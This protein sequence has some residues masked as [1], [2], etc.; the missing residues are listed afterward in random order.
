MGITIATHNGSAYRYWHNI[1]NP[2]TVNK[3]PHINPNGIHENWIDETAQNAYKRIFGEAVLAYNEK[4][5][6]SDRKI[7]NYYRDICKDAKKHPVYEMI[8]GIYGTDKETGKPLCDEKT[9][10]EIMHEFVEDW[11]KRNPNLEIIGAYYHAD[12]EGE[13]HVHIDY[14]PVAHNCTR[15]MTTQNSLVRALNEQGFYT[16][17]AKDTAQMRWE[18]RENEYLEKLCNDRGFTVEHPAPEKVKHTETALYKAQKA[19]DTAID[20]YNGIDAL[21]DKAKRELALIEKQTQRALTRKAKA[22]ALKKTGETEYTYDKGLADGIKELVEERKKDAEALS[23]TDYEVQQK[24]QEAE[25]KL[26]QAE[27]LRRQAERELQHEQRT[28][29]QEARR[30]S[31]RRFEEF[32][33]QFLQSDETGYTK[34]L[35]QFTGTLTLDGENALDIFHREEQERVEE[36]RKAFNGKEK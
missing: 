22:L 24:Y 4:Q 5:K 27:E 21:V 8:I 10:K 29:K 23:K 30:L 28:I 14:I 7:Q 33:E 6:R 35:E 19:R 12:E 11:K 17:N 2:N 32:A 3:E 1:R 16:K 18:H 20:D 34:R 26:Q 15:G 25:L 13:P 36:L 9:G 31:D